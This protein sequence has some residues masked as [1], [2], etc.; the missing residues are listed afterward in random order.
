[1]NRVRRI[2]PGFYIKESL[3]AMEMTSKEFSIRTGISERTLSA[4]IN[5][6]GNITFDVAYKLSQ[7]FDSSITFWTNLQTE[8]ELYLR[9]NEAYSIEK[10]DFKLIKP[11]KKYLID[12]NYILEEDSEGTV[13]KKCRSLAGVNSLSLLNKKDPFACFK[14]QHYA[15]KS[16][17][18]LQNFWIALAL[19]EARRNRNKSFN[20]QKLLNSIPELRCLTKEK[21][22]IFYP[23]LKEIFEQSGVCFVLL[24]YLPNSNIYGVTKWLSFDNVMVAVSNRGGN[25]NLFWFTLF[26]E[27][28]HVLMG[29]KREALLNLDGSL[30][31]KADKMALDMLIPEEEWLRFSK[32][33]FYSVKSINEF[34][35]KIGIHPC[36]V[37]GR[38]HKERPDKVPYG[39]FDKQINVAYDTSEMTTCN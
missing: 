34:A 38:L 5:G 15:K 8:F 31:A 23:R 11:I 25:A 12:F 28:S 29:H 35:L 32:L 4:I 26:H 17:P 7:Y 30:D 13:V 36:I 19:N 3:D 2:H 10:E 6:N 33:E 18:F 27:I 39:M 24:P 22:S 14:E 9:E 21:I 16:D 20:K 37:L 1:M